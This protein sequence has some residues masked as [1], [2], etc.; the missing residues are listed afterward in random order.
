M[1]MYSNTK[2]CK[3]LQR[4]T[5]GPLSMASD[6]VLQNA[7]GSLHVNLKETNGRNSGYSDGVDV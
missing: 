6:K 1:V 3:I 2:F 7:E 5:P 4:L